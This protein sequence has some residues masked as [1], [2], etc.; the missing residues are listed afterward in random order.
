MLVFLRGK[1]LLLR[2]EDGLD[3]GQLEDLIGWRIWFNRRIWLGE[4]S[5]FFG[6]FGLVEGLGSIG[7]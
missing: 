2:F 6:G 3:L 1:Y 7:V 5:C 4:E